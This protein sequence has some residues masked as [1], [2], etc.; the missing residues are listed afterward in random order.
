MRLCRREGGRKGHIS[1]KKTRGK[2]DA[3]KAG[4][5]EWGREGGGERGQAG[6]RDGDYRPTEKELTM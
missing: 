4:R 5:R 3:G 1:E 6:R 2:R